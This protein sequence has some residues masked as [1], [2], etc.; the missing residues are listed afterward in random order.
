MGQ[1]LLWWDTDATLPCDS[2][3]LHIGAEK[4]LL[5]NAQL[6]AVSRGLHAAVTEEI[7]E[8]MPRVVVSS[9]GNHKIVDLN[10]EDGASSKCESNLHL[11]SVLPLNWA[12]TRFLARFIDQPYLWLHTLSVIRHIERGRYAHLQSLC[13]YDRL[14]LTH[15]VEMSGKGE[16]TGVCVNPYT[17]LPSFVFLHC[18]FSTFS[19]GGC[20]FFFEHW[21]NPYLALLH[22]KSICYICGWPEQEPWNIY[23]KTP[24]AREEL[25]VQ[26]IIVILVILIMLLNNNNNNS[27]NNNYTFPVQRLGVYRDHLAN[28]FCP[29]FPIFALQ[30]P[31]HAGVQKTPAKDCQGLSIKFES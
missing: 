27:S 7:K 23:C 6:Q 18:V 31:I 30:P 29:D 20:G 9:P 26:I 4:C 3:I 16:G 11:G 17:V 15:S 2:G 10:P 12:V 28:S 8:R 1:N 5:G 24:S 14:S 19:V 21:E 25:R 13:C 22:P